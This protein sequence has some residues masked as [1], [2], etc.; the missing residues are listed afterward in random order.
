MQCY[1]NVIFISC[2]YP[3]ESFFVCHTT[4]A[5]VEVESASQSSQAVTS[6]CF[7]ETTQCSAHPY[8]TM[9]ASS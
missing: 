1:S 4:E 6:L 5:D 3:Q 7:S 9:A 2:N 8:V